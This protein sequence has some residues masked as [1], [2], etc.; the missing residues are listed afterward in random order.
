VL[1]PEDK[2]HGVV[3]VDIGGA[4]T[5]IAI[6]IQGGVWH[7]SVI[8]IGGSHFTNDLVYVLHTPHNTAEY[9]KLKYGSAIAEAVEEGADEGEDDLI[10]AETL[11]AGEQQQISR[12]LMN[13]ILQARSED[14]VEMIYNEIQRSGYDGLLQAGIVVTGGGA[15]LARLDEL[16]REMLGIPVRVGIPTGLTG[17]SDTLDSAP[18]ST[19][20]GLLRWGAYQGS[21]VL[22]AP[23]DG[24]ERGGRIRLGIYERLKGWLRE[25]LP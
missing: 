11:V 10:D 15:Q 20:I 22:D 21:S 1:T 9:L 8:P 17:L 14:L 18:Y 3:L 16:M 6:F 5:D 25:F 19:S 7:T 13:E 12:Q 24:P 4:T 23:Y 2:E